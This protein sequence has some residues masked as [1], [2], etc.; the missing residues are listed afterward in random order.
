MTAHH[1]HENLTTSQRVFQTVPEDQRQG[2]ALAKLVRTSRRLG[3]LWRVSAYLSPQVAAALTYPGAAQFGKHPVPRGIQ[4]LEVLTG[5]ASLAKNKSFFTKLLAGIAGQQ[6]KFQSRKQTKGCKTTI[7]TE[8]H[9]R[10]PLS[11]AP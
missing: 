1:D 4:A 5:T 8:R 7:V 9:D 3:G 2:K 11:F 6:D 10:E